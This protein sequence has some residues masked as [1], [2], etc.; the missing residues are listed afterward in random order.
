MTKHEQTNIVGPDKTRSRREQNETYTGYGIWDMVV[1][2][3]HDD[4]I[5]I[6]LHPFW[7]A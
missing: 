3:D 1:D 7:I 6:T 4:N 2:N 5:I